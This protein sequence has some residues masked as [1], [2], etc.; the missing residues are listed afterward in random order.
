M[1]AV[2]KTYLHL[3]SFISFSGKYQAHSVDCGYKANCTQDKQVFWW[4]LCEL[5]EDVMK[6]DFVWDNK[7]FSSE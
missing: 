2:R 3:I 5:A 6:I 4:Q 7:E 1:N